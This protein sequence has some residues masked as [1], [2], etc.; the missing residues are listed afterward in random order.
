MEKTACQAYLMNNQE[1]KETLSSLGYILLDRGP[2]WQ[3]N[4][5]YRNGDNKTALQIYKDSGVWKDH[6][7]QTPFM[8]LDKLIKITLGTTD[9]DLV[10]SY[11]KKKDPFSFESRVNVEPKI[12]MEKIYEEKYLTETRSNFDNKEILDGYLKNFK[13]SL[14]S[15]PNI[16]DERKQSILDNEIC[17]NQKTDLN[18]NILVKSQNGSFQI[19]CFRL[20]LSQKILY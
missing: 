13:Q 11:I 4:A 8:P 7:Q 2:Y 19:I 6:V 1:I 12:K 18:G 17:L 3:T 14:N 16:S 9:Q 20:N 10:N 15:I 5:I